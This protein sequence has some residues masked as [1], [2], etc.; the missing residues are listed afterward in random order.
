MIELVIIE[1]NTKWASPVRVPPR[2]IP[3]HYKQ[4]VE[5]QI[6]EMLKQGI[7]RESSSPWL[8]PCVY[9]PKKNGELRICVLYLLV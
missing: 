8:A 7:I 2:R 5:R 6:N 3:Q 1:I 9:V 4:E